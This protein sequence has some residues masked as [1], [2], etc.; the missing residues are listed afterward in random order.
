MSREPGNDT[1]AP[2]ELDTSPRGRGDTSTPARRDVCLWCGVQFPVGTRRDA[3]YCGKRC[4][5]AAWR[6]ARYRVRAT[7][8]AVSRRWAYADPPYPGLAERYYGEHED[9]AGEVDHRVLLSR[10]QVYDGWALSTSA[11]ALPFVL[12]LCRELGYQTPLAGPAT[13]PEYRQVHVAAWFR[14]GRPGPV[15]EPRQAWEPVVY[16]GGRRLADPSRDV[17]DDALVLQAR[18]RTTDPRRV[19]GAKPAG[20]AFW[21][22]GLLCAQAGD[23]LDDLFPGSRGIDRAWGMFVDPSPRARPDTSG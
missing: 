20:F 15:C 9:Y 18:P 16:A 8:A 10:L 2:A 12:G 13:G 1:S 6:F 7:V 23:T 5:Q 11:D 4:R 22:F 17:V 19:M 3:L 14:G 21:M